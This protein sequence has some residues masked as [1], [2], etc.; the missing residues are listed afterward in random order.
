MHTALLLGLVSLS[1]VN[2][3]QLKLTKGGFDVLHIAGLCPCLGQQSSTWPLPRLVSEA[4][5]EAGPVPV[6]ARTAPPALRGAAARQLLGRRHGTRRVRGRKRS[7]GDTGRSW[8][9]PAAVSSQTT[10]EG[11]PHPHTPTTTVHT[12]LSKT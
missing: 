1:I 2:S 3:K 5:G 10:A 8:R 6:T 7:Y 9:Q 11:C 4:G 12:E